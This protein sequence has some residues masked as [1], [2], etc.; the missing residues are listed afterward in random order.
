MFATLS[1]NG[2]SRL[3]AAAVHDGH[4]LRPEVERIIALDEATRLREEDPFTG[5]LAERFDKSVVVHRSRFEVDLNRE[6]ADAVYLSPDDAWDLDVW[7]YPPDEDMVSASLELFDSFYAN[8]AMT[9]DDMVEAL[10]GFVLYDIHAYNHRRHG[11][12]APPEDAMGNPTV[13]LGT[14]SLPGRWRPVAEAFLETLAGQ[15]VEGEPIDARENIRFKGRGLP[16][17]VHDN[18]PE[19]GCTLAIEVKKVFMD[20]WTGRLFPEVHHQIGDALVATADPVMAAWS[21]SVGT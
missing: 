5:E 13:N 17:F 6:R 19:K 18:Y 12:D 2:E 20:E 14:G 9:L 11:P 15:L 4:E 7:E 8:L 3:I 1:H 16:A 10:G 21:S